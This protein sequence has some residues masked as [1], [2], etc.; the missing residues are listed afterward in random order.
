MVNY[1]KLNKLFSKQVRQNFYFYKKSHPLT[2][3]ACQKQPT[4]CHMKAMKPIQVFAPYE[5]KGNAIEYFMFIKWKRGHKGHG[6]HGGHR[7]HK[8]TKGT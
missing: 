7:K 2:S 4:C 5:K 3:Y 6:G 8:E 1:Q